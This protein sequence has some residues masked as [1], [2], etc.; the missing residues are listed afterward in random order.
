M[1]RISMSKLKTS[2]NSRV[3]L[4]SPVSTSGSK[5]FF[6]SPLAR[7]SPALEPLTIPNYYLA[8][9]PDAIRHAH[10]TIHHYIT[11]KKLSVA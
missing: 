2:G 1:L 6:V 4:Q 7:L 5:V 8:V 3:T 9:S 10:S 11:E